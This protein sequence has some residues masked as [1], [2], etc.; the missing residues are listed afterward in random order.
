MEYKERYN[1]WKKLTLDAEIAAELL[2]IEND[3]AEI[4]SRFSSEL[5]FGTAGL[6]GKLGAGTNR[7]NVYTVGR[8]SQGL[9]EYVLRNG[10]QEKGMVIACDTRRSSALFA[11]TTALVF[12][13]NGIKTRLFGEATS[14]PELSFAV[15]H[16]GAFGGVVITASHNPKDY[17]GYKVYAPWGGQ[18]LADSSENVMCCI[19]GVCG[20]AEVKTMGMDE[21]TASGLLT[22]IGEEIDSEYYQ[23]LAGM[24]KRPDLIKKH[25]K[26]IHL[27]YTPLFGTGLRTF[28][29]V[30]RSF[31]YEHTLVKEQCMPD[32][33]FPGLKAPNPEDETAME[34]AVKLAGDIG[35]DMAFGT[36][37]D[38]DRLGVA[39]RNEQGEFIMLSGNQIGCLIADYLIRQRK[40]SGE[41]SASDY[42]VKS[43][44]ST[45]MADKIA[46]KLGAEC[47]TV[48]TGF[49]YIADV[50]NTRKEGTFIFGFEE[51]GGF[52]AGDFVMDKDGVMALL[53]M[54]EVACEC[55]EAGETLYQRLR[56]L[57]ESYGWHKEKV[58]SA[59]M[60]GDGGMER[61]AAIMKR[62]RET[63]PGTLGG[64]SV[65]GFTDYQSGTYKDGEGTRQIDFPRENALKL[66]MENGWVSVRPSGTEPKIKLYVAAYGDTKESAE[67]FFAALEKD[68]AAL[69][70]V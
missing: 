5:C 57:Y 60:E 28:E 30:M 23:R 32:P 20:T 31:S 49:K 66:S 19:E 25:G 56:S 50:I 7:M 48:P 29:G 68:A 22:I 59:V 38:A 3:E 54:L 55:K 52:L 24:A 4:K 37:P 10:G 46:Q 9:A 39:V 11:K 43:F 1:E 21:A 69:V 64:Q 47:I 63:P 44:V 18:L 26:G 33:D 13:A 41:L 14:V 27:V 35:A 70:G 58:I 36:D 8:A 6:R 16:Y 12:A 62:L 42:I 61:K 15:R 2:N 53:L 34:K 65:T 51:S 67:T 40:R 17:N 45:A